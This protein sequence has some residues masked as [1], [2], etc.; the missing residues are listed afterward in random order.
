MELVKHAFPLV[1]ALARAR[2]R[3][4]AIELIDKGADFQMREAFE[5]ALAI[6]R[7]A[8]VRLGD[9]PDAADALV[10]SIRVRDTERLGIEA[11]EG[12]HARRGDVL[13][14]NTPD[15]KGNSR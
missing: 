12:L 15:P 10:A 11:V 1:P 5:S 4:H 14:V 7:D 13:L 8:L 9:T 2:D 6:S 3:Q